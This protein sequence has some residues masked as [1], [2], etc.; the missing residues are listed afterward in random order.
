MGRSLHLRLR[1]QPRSSTLACDVLNKRHSKIWTRN[2]DHN[3]QQYRRSTQRKSQN[4][5]S[6]SN[7]SHKSHKSHNYTLNFI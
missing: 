6:Q 5:H 3:C 2:F 1:R 4:H 7:T